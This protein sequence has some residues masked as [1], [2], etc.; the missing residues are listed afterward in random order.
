[1]ELKADKIIGWLR[2]HGEHGGA[3]MDTSKLHSDENS[4]ELQKMYFG[5]R[6]YSYDGVVAN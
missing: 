1:M 4:E 2:T 6:L 5:Q 3:I